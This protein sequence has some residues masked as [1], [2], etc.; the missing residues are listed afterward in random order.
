M[1]ELPG[2][3]RILMLCEV[4][5]YAP[6]G[7]TEFG[8]SNCYA[9]G[10]Y[11]HMEACATCSGPGPSHCTS[12]H[13]KPVPQPPHRLVP[14]RRHAN[15]AEGSCVVATSDMKN[16]KVTNGHEAIL[17]KWA[18]LP[19]TGIVLPATTETGL[20]MMTFDVV[21]SMFKTMICQKNM[22]GNTECTVKKEVTLQTI[23]KAWLE[24][25]PKAY[26]LAHAIHGQD[27]CKTSGCQLV[28]MYIANLPTEF[29][30]SFAN[31]SSIHEVCA[32]VVQLS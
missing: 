29:M 14:W 15:L 4:E 31:V 21:C 12:C 3:N 22:N 6:W 5:V 30:T 25:T 11:P 1:I 7:A 28:R 2:R 8:V 24:G 17:T 32:D 18:L 10:I 26:Q 16:Q 9:G 27:S 23:E 20:A 13:Q 19:S